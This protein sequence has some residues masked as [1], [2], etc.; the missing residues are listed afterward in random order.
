MWKN[1][2]QRRRSRIRRA[3]RDLW[4]WSP[5]AA[6]GNVAAVLECLSQ[7][8]HVHRRHPSEAIWRT[9]GLSVPEILGAIS[10]RSSPA[11]DLLAARG[12]RT[13]CPLR[14]VVVAALASHV[15]STSP[16]VPFPREKCSTSPPIARRPITSKP[17]RRCSAPMLVNND[18]FDRVSDFLRPEHFS[19]ELHRRI[20][21]VSSQIIRAGRVAT[22]GDAEDASRRSGAARRRDDAGLSRADRRARRRRSSTPRIMA[23]RSMISR[24]GVS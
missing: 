4:H 2:S 10:S 18:A 23:A 6:W 21:E 13:P 1:D 9:A 20:F 3:A 19:E 8:V 16:C 24:C 17:S 14:D 7:R 12:T 11:L 15:P 22:V 5:L